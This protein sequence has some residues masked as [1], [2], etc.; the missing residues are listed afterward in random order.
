MSDQRFTLLNY[1]P[2]ALL[3][4]AV[5]ALGTSLT[6]VQRDI[7]ELIS[8]AAMYFGSSNKW[9]CRLGGTI[10]ICCMI[11]LSLEGLRGLAR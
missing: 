7:V 4:L 8:G 2:W 1:A 6:H 9:V 10:V 3:M 11:A 5:C